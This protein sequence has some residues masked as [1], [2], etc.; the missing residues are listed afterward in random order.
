[1]SSGTSKSTKFKKNLRLK[2]TR[3]GLFVSVPLPSAA[4]CSN[5][6]RSGNGTAINYNVAKAVSFVGRGVG[7]LFVLFFVLSASFFLPQPP[8][9]SL[10][11]PGCNKNPCHFLWLSLPPTAWMSSCTRLCNRYHSSATS[12]WLQKKDPLCTVSLTLH[13]CPQQCRGHTGRGH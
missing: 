12:W 13:N 6:N 11:Q 1:M 4:N 2:D 9:H 10:F 8:L 7:V 5:G 3:T